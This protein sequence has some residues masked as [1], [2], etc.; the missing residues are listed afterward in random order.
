MN[1]SELDKAK[2]MLL[3]D[4]ARMRIISDYPILIEHLEK[5]LAE[6]IEKKSDHVELSLDNALQLMKHLKKFH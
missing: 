2:K 5:S 4:D 6:A 3:G 1:K